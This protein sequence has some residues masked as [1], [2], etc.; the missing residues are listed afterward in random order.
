MPAPDPDAIE[1]GPGWPEKVEVWFTQ[2]F[3]DG[4]RKHRKQRA[5]SIAKNLG[6]GGWLCRFCCDPVPLY[7]RADAVFCSEGCKRRMARWRRLD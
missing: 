7:K 6:R 5:I 3:W 4:N 1:I 2:P